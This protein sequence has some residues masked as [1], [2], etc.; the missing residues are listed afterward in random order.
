[1]LFDEA[2]AEKM[3]KVAVAALA[4]VGHADPDD[5][6]TTLETPPPVLLK[7]LNLGRM[8]VGMA[9]FDTVEEMV[10]CAI[11]QFLSNG[12]DLEAI[13]WMKYAA[14]WD[15]EYQ[16]DDFDMGGVQ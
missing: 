4:E 11:G 7:A 14:R 10:G 1:M 16:L 15:I 6:R 9:P 3:A 12:G 5:T 8:A 13:Q 2:A